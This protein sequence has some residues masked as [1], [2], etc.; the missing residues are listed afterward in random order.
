MNYPDLGALEVG[1]EISPSCKMYA[2]E[3]ALLEEGALVADN[4]ERFVV[5]DYLFYCLIH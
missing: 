1:V 5:G 4:L 2:D 3:R